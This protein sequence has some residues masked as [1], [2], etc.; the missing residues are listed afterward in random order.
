MWVY[1][2]SCA[3]MRCCSCECFAFLLDV[4]PRYKKR[5]SAGIVL[6]AQQLYQMSLN[7]R[8]A[9]QPV[10]KVVKL[11]KLDKQ[12]RYMQKSGQEQCNS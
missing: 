12:R 7:S 10:G 5:A 2:F 6:W 1:A 8:H 11:V 9:M 3:S 4:L